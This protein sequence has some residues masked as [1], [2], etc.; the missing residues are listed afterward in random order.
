[1]L[2]RLARGTFLLLLVAMVAAWAVSLAETSAAA[3]QYD[4]DVYWFC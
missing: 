2:V 3:P 4:P 1:M